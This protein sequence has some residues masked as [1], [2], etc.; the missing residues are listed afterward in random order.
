MA[1]LC[2]E[3]KEYNNNMKTKNILLSVCFVL[4]SSFTWA[5]PSS[6]RISEHVKRATSRSVA[7]RYVQEK[8]QFLQQYRQ[9]FGVQEFITLYTS[10]LGPS[11]RGHTDKML[12]LH[13]PEKAALTCWTVSRQSQNKAISPL[14]PQAGEKLQ[15]KTKDFANW[16]LLPRQGKVFV[17]VKMQGLRSLL[18]SLSAPEDLMEAYIAGKKRPS[19]LKQ[20][21]SLQFCPQVT[22][23]SLR[24]QLDALPDNDKPYITIEA[25]Y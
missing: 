18:A 15:Q 21:V 1:L 14:V 9:T 16:Q 11:L 20:F 22:E 13:V 25:F 12:Q 10:S 17:H 19:Q 23:P 4:L 24:A 6:R 7:Q 8:K 5:Q 3:V 2:A